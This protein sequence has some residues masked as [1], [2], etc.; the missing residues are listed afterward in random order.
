VRETRADRATLIVLSNVPFGAPAMITREELYELVW[1]KPMTKVAEQFDVSSSYMARVC[2]VLRVPRPERGY[3]AKLAVAKAPE[4]QP[5]P[6][7][8][9]G[10]QVIWSKGGDLQAHPTHKPALP[11]KLQT[12]RPAR[13]VIGTHGLIRGAK[14]HFE[15]GRQVEEGQYLKPYKKLLVDI[16]TSKAGL[17]KALAFANDLFNVLESA[18]HRVVLAPGGE[19]LRRHEVEVHEQPK[20]REH[21]HYYYTHP[22]W[23]YRPTIVYVG[24][25]AIGLSIVEMSE[26]VLMRHVKGKYIRDAD[27][28][29]PK[30][31]RRYV[32]HTWTTTQDLPCGRLRLIAYCP[33]PR[34]SWSTIWQETKNA[35][36]TRALHTIVKEIENAAVGLIEKLKEAEQQAEVT[37]LKW[38]AEEE[39]RRHEEDRRCIQQSIN[40]SQA[41]LRQ[42]IQA[43]ADVMNVGRFLQGVQDHA[44]DLPPKERD[45][46]LERLKLAREFVGTQNPLKF[47]LSWRT[48]LERYQPLSARSGAGAKIEE[49]TK[50]KDQNDPSV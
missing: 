23:P 1:S 6:E 8:E 50:D 7:A 21:D 41:Q 15:S 16:T 42:I 18:G 40:D 24:A 17:D 27:Y 20:K 12:S 46:V 48:P 13:L 5:L 34:V 19:Q 36:L 4:R 32:D 26:A 22:W 44:S 11:L 31:Y 9:P 35:P 3:W 30:A 2:T 39:K 47:F 14:A 10:D 43:W 28:V 29:P 38:L 25:L 49:N 45:E 37:R 33:Y